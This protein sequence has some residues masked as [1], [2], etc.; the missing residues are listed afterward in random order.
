MHVISEDDWDKYLIA[1]TKRP[2][3]L[4]KKNIPPSIQWYYI[5]RVDKGFG[6]GELY[7]EP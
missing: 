5:G 2:L 1:S 6:R 4:S 3:Y 7:N